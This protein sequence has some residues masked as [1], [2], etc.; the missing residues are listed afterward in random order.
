MLRKLAQC[1]IKQQL[2]RIS[3]FSLN[4]IITLLCFSYEADMTLQCPSPTLV[5]RAST[6]C[7][8]ARS[9][10]AAPST[11]SLSRK[12]IQ[13]YVKQQLPRIVFHFSLDIIIT[14]L[15]SI[16]YANISWRVTSQCSSPTLA[17]LART[18]CS[19]ARSL[20]FATTPFRSFFVA[21][22]RPMPHKT[23]LIV[24]HN[25]SLCTD[26]HYLTGLCISYAYITCE[27]LRIFRSALNV[28]TLALYFLR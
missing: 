2:P 7:L 6:P 11:S 12:L 18:R 13:C 24:S 25:F 8:G 9:L 10:A 27:L 23:I 21:K 3:H 17:P 14:L 1:Y 22:T 19:G 5:P 4:I 28:I 26:H 20:A 16:S 15:C